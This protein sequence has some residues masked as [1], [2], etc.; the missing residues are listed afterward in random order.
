[1]ITTNKIKIIAFVGL[2]G[3]GKSVAVDY[4]TAKGYPK[5]YFGG[6]ILDALTET[7]LE[8]TQENEK[9]FREEIRARE[10]KDFVAQRII[11]QIHSLIDAGQHRIVADGLYSWTE[12]KVLKHEFPGELEL[13]AIVAPK[14][15][16]HYRLLTRPVRPLT[17]TE[18]DQR[19]WAEIEGI[20]KGG[21]IAIADHFII[22]DGSMEQLHEQ[23]DKV[24]TDIDFI[25]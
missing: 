20:E 10:G 9:K 19:D 17:Q 22:N 14:R 5:V 1:M 4:V 15:L 3:A 11:K 21:P 13:V 18:S 23:V 16:R 12:Y 24:L 7:G 8:H 2:A 6:V 25:I